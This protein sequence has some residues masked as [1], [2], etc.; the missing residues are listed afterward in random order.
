GGLWR[1]LAIAI[2]LAA[3]AFLGPSPY[4]LVHPHQAWADTS[5]VQRLARDGWL[6][7]EHDSWSLFS[8]TGKLWNGFGPFLVIA[9]VGLVIAL[10]RRARTALTL[11]V[12]VAAHLA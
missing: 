12:F 4:V 8:F 9:I 1:R 10:R 7:F 2:G 11:A 6:G 3:L 5:R